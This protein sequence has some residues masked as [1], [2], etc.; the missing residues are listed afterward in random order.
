MFIVWSAGSALAIFFFLVSSILIFAMHCKEKIYWVP[1]D[2]PQ[3]I[4]AGRAFFSV[5]FKKINKKIIW[6]SVT[7]MITCFIRLYNVCFQVS[8][9]HSNEDETRT[10]WKIIARVIVIFQILCI[11]R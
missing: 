6:R 1:Y 9:I 11:P 3:L 10:E 4:F 8:A 7:H 2:F 5:L